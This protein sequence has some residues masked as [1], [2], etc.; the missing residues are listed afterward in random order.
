ME[1]T[2]E[3]NIFEQATRLQ[4]RFDSPK[5]QLSV[6]DL[7]VLSL[8]KLNDLAKGLKRKLKETEEEDFLKT[9]SDTDKKVDLSFQVVLY[10]LQ[11]KKAEAEDRARVAENRAMKQKLLEKIEQKKDKAYDDMTVEQLQEQLSKL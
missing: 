2:T 5:G 3:I 10:I 1:N 11:T 8:E 4:L 9:R 6:E 7:W